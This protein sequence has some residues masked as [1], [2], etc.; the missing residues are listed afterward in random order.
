MEGKH[1]L[2]KASFL[3]VATL[4]SRVLALV[5]DM[6]MAWLVG[7]GPVADCL[8]AALR[9][10]HAVR[11]LLAEGSLSMT[12]TAWFAQTH[13]LHILNMARR[14]SLGLAAFLGIFVFLALWGSPWL[15]S[16]LLPGF[17]PEH[18]SLAATLLQLALPYMFWAGLAAMSMALL[19]SQRVFG[20]SALSPVVFNLTILT[21]TLAAAYLPLPQAHTIALGM[22]CGG[23][24]QWLIQWQATRKLLPA[25]DTQIDCVLPVRKTFSPVRGGQLS[26]GLVGAAA[27][28]LVLLAAM[29]LAST[30]LPGAVTA[31]Y[32]AERILELPLGLVGVCLGMA[33]L[34]TLSRH[35]ADG[36]M[37]AFVATLHIAIR[38]ALWLGL[39][40]CA[41]LWA[42]GGLLV[43]LLFGHGNFTVAAV[44]ETCVA[45]AIYAPAIP[46]CAVGR[47]L[48]AACNALGLVRQ[49]ALSAAWS[50]LVTV[51]LGVCGMPPAV[52]AGL[53]L[54]V[55]PLLLWRC[56]LKHLDQ[57]GQALGNFRPCLL[58]G[59]LAAVA[60]GGGAYLVRIF[61]QKQEIL[62]LLLSVVAGSLAWGATLLATRRGL[63]CP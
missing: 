14:M 19:H 54:C 22:T 57:Q 35:A 44:E 18:Q 31:L 33:S 63:T 58:Q 25:Q 34:P 37:D 51:A 4:L 20:P 59:L 17:T 9:L 39:A 12:L 16:M 50:L 36:N 49:T 13:P 55:Q 24:V 53:G 48:L 10:P 45:L 21:F 61:L 32:Y 62:A 3:G 42:V 29:G 43:P 7:A 15:A 38:W 23:F 1:L 56:L 11:R 47:N 52:A 6:A 41:G 2:G 46:V 27:P 30:R 8:V 26:A 28:Q 60:T 40:A 5:R